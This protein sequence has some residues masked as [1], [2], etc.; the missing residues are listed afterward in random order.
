LN[1]VPRLLKRILEED[2]WRER[3]DAKTRTT[4]GFQQF[5][6]FVA[7]P[8]TEGLGASIGLVERIVKGTEAEELLRKAL[9][10]TYNISTKSRMTG[11]GTRRD[12]ALER[13]RSE[14]PE[15]HAE[16]LAGALSP[17]AAMVK[18]GFR[19]RTFTVQ[20]DNPERIAAT[21]RRQLDPEQLAELTRLLTDNLNGMRDD[22][23]PALE[24]PFRVYRQVV[25]C[26]E[27]P[28]RSVG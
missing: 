10:G 9:K 14:A 8:P 1:Y 12:Y 7:A 15:L 26:G 4:V 20:A 17:H 27:V 6:E 28:A 16:V 11:H 25:T 24:S 2:A 22:N 5:A 19:H 21:L 13:L 3:I 18:A 23:N